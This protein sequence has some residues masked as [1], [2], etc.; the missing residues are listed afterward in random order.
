MVIKICQERQLSSLAPQ[1]SVVCELKQIL[2]ED[3]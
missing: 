3:A 1:D 2:T